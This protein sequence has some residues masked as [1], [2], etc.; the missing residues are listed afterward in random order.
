MIHKI[1]KNGIKLAVVPIEGLRAVTVEASVK[2]G[3]KYEEPQEHGLSH[4]LEHMA[5]KGTSKRPKQMDVFREMD[6]RG[7]DFNAETGLENTSYSITTVRSNLDW[8]VDMVN[9]IIFNSIM[10]EDEV[11]KERGVICEEIKMYKDNPMMGLGSE[12]M[13]FV[14]GKSKLGC[15]NI[16]GELDQIQKVGREDIINFQNKYFN[17][18]AMTVVL[19]G[20]VQE[21]DLKLVES[22][23][24]EVRTGKVVS[25]VPIEINGQMKSVESRQVEG[26]HLALAVPSFG[27]ESDKRYTARLLDIILSGNSSS[28]L[29]SEIRSNR[30]WAYYVFPISE[31]FR[32]AGM[33]GVQAGVSLANL[34]D[35]VKVIKEIIMT[36]GKTINEDELIRAKN[37][38]NG[39]IELHLDQSEFWSGYVGSKWLLEDRLT[40][41]MEELKIIEKST[42]GEV[43]SLA[44]D[45]FKAEEIREMTVLAK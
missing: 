22:I 12:M 44:N 39:R 45:L 34:D 24:S 33:W 16:S 35:A 4:F 37:Y 10:P 7:A 8:A 15:F 18:E 20:N 17:T 42:L 23:F 28:R 29:F 19:A 41:P 1:L 43:R 36:V 5:F 38:L 13:K 3:A 32:E 9:D 26:G 2:I 25:K 40:T 30:G 6:V 11:K 27:W 31:M 14:F 21:A